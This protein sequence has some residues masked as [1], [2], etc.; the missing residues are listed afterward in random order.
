M[1]QDL[2]LADWLEELA[3]YGTPRR[4]HDAETAHHLSQAIRHS[5]IVR[6]AI[7]RHGLTARVGPISVQ[8]LSAELLLKANDQ[9]SSQAARPLRAGRAADRL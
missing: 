7:A 5:Y 2:A 9:K 3:I 8:G 4:F 6:L 1:N